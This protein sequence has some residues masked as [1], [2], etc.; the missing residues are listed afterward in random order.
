MLIL[1]CLVLKIMLQNQIQKGG[2]FILL[3]CSQKPS[4]LYC[5]TYARKGRTSVTSLHKKIQL[6]ECQK[7]IARNNAFYLHSTV[8]FTVRYYACTSSQ[9]VYYSKLLVFAVLR[10]FRHVAN[11]DY[12][13]KPSQ[14]I[15]NY[16]L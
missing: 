1:K 16:V 9:N 3:H 7:L 12:L 8:Y 15:N 4:F 6:P 14:I 10:I 2:R 13:L 11:F 5:F